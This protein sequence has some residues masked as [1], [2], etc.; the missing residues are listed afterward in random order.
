MNVT[1][2]YVENNV[3]KNNIPPPKQNGECVY[4]C[5][6]CDYKISSKSSFKKHL[7]SKKHAENYDN[8]GI[9]ITF[10]VT[11]YERKLYKCNFCNEYLFSRTQRSTHTKKKS[12]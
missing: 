1:D 11:K 2:K 6:H 8:K 5:R 10:D 12:L 4:H 7:E 3:V 9:E